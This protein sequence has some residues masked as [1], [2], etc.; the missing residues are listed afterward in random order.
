MATRGGGASG[1][2]GLGYGPVSGRGF[3]LVEVGFLYQGLGDAFDDGFD[4]E[5]GGG[6]DKCE[7]GRQGAGP[8][9]VELFFDAG[10]AAVA[11]G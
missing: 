8:E 11:G 7:D 4:N 1:L 5:A 2:R 10:E 6:R 3:D 9:D